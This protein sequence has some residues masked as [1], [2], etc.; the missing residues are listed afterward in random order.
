MKL[1]PNNRL[2]KL[3]VLDKYDNDFFSYECDYDLGRVAVS[4]ET[5]GPVIRTF[6]DHINI[7]PYEF[8]S[9]AKFDALGIEALFLSHTICDTRIRTIEDVF[10]RYVHRDIDSSG[11]AILISSQE[12]QKVKRKI[13]KLASSR[14]MHAQMWKEIAT[15]GMYITPN[16]YFFGV[17]SERPIDDKNSHYGIAIINTAAIIKTY[18]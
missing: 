16:P 4:K 2:S 3:L 7:V 13:C 8:D 15:G 12:D 1:S 17:I 5:N 18:V 6:G 14:K 11:G 9:E 10:D